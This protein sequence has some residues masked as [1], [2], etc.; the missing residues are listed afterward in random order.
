MDNKILQGRNH[1]KFL[2][3]SQRPS[4]EPDPQP[5]SVQ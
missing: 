2:L 1:I 4:L 3:L 5:T